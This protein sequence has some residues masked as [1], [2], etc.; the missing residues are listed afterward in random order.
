MYISKVSEKGP[1]FE[2]RSF[3]QKKS[4]LRSLNCNI[5]KKDDVIIYTD[6]ANGNPI[7]LVRTGVKI[8]YTPI[9]PVIR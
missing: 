3:F 7:T 1:S 5:W 2:S 9:R 8:Y 4:Y 6:V